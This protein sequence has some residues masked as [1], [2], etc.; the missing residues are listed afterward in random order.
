MHL[1]I[2]MLILWSFSLLVSADEPAAQA[3]NRVILN[4]VNAIANETRTLDEILQAWDGTLT[5]ALQINSQTSKIMKA[6]AEGTKAA[7]SSRRL[8][9]RNALRV[10]RATKRLIRDTRNVTGDLVFMKDR[11]R[12]IT[13]AG[14]V[15][16]NLK[17]IQAA[18]DAMNK[19]VVRKLPGIGRPIGRRMGRRVHKIFQRAI[20]EYDSKDPA[21]TPT[22][23]TKTWTKTGGGPG[24][25][26]KKRVWVATAGAGDAASLEKFG[27]RRFHHGP[28]TVPTSTEP[29]PTT[30]E[31]VSTS[32]RRYTVSPAPPTPT[33]ET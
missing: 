14:M 8:N 29:A 32:T 4:A 13:L 30:A 16:A 27:K 21:P 17:K 20:D 1:N 2:F 23:P 18:S 15:K 5:G 7:N 31:S 12:A 3:P 22:P 19:V 33:S 9:I 24:G 6:I 25:G 10:G 28:G 26:S 11:F